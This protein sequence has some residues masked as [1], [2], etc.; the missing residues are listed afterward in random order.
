MALTQVTPGVY[1]YGAYATPQQ[2]KVDTEGAKAMGEAIGKGVSGIIKEIQ[3]N[4]ERKNELKKSVG[5][6]NAY[7]ADSFAGDNEK[8]IYE[9]SEAYSEWIKDSNK[10]FRKDKEEYYRKKAFWE[11]NMNNIKALKDVSLQGM[12]DV[13]L[14]DIKSDDFQKYL[15][16]TQISNGSYLLEFD[17]E[18]GFNINLNDIEIDSYSDKDNDFEISPT[19]K[20]YIK[21]TENFKSSK[22]FSVSSASQNKIGLSNLLNEYDS[23]TGFRMKFNI[24]DPDVVKDFQASAKTI[25]ETRITAYLTEDKN[26]RE[27]LNVDSVVADIRDSVY[28]DDLVAR[29]GDQINEDM[30]DGSLSNSDVRDYITA[31]V[32]DRVTYVGDKK[33]VES[34]LDWF[35]A[36]TDRMKADAAITRANKEQQESETSKAWNVTR[37]AAE[38]GLALVDSVENAGD[39]LIDLGNLAKSERIEPE[40]GTPL[41]NLLSQSGYSIDS[42]VKNDDGDVIGFYI[43]PK[44]GA[45]KKKEFLPI[46]KGERQLRNTLRGIFTNNI[47]SANDYRGATSTQ[48]TSTQGGESDGSDNSL[49]IGGNTYG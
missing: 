41:F 16:K 34:A 5:E 40:A 3:N 6:F 24:S 30:F 1:N 46:G 36:K 23:Y 4:A 32:I 45:L 31:N 9:F 28:I 37:G 8:A 48:S 10:L 27:Y 17:P 14:G 44:A 19:S 25:D 26:G 49:T 42:P 35:K 22:Q 15:Y 2:V 11:N 12:T 39:W 47:N 7:T 29:Y 43:M 20:T 18:K 21:D 13:D 33:P 38:R